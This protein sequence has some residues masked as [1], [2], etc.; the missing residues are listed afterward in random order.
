LRPRT[1]IDVAPPDSGAPLDA[2]M[3]A[4]ARAGEPDRYLAALLAP[5]AARP[6]LL[7]LAAFFSEL[8]RAATLVREPGMGEI[9]LQ[10]WRQALE[11]AEGLR[12]GNPIADAVRNVA[13]RK[14]LPAALLIDVI[15]ARASDLHREMLEDDAALQAYLWKREGV[16]FLL[17]A[18][19]LGGRPGRLLDAA[20]AA[21]A[22]AYGLVRLLQGMPR[23]LARGRLALPTTYLRAVGLEPETIL[24]GGPRPSGGLSGAEGGKGGLSGAEGEPLAALLAELFAD[25]RRHL[26]ACR[27]HVANLPR[28]VGPAFLPLAL[29]ASYLRGLERAGV[30]VLRS[31]TEIAPL[32][33]VCR[34]A[35]AHWLRRI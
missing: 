14:R 33:R 25:V 32:T 22:R 8:Q 19:V 24:S 15:D 18:A 31:P 29:V 5:A 30:G 13:R 2:A 12:T 28:E 35:A 10:W 16:A 4:A 11:L 23:A 21:G 6:D 17:A 26:A 9:R 27:Q 3:L 34:M 7:V 1:S 20:A